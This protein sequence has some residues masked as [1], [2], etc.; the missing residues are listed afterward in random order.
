MEESEWNGIEESEWNGI[1]ESEWNSIEESEW[2]GRMVD[3]DLSISEKEQGK[4]F[5]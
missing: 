2:N 5:I 1:E 4:N 3:T